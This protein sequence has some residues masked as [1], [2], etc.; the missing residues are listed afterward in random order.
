MTLNAKQLQDLQKARKRRELR[1]VPSVI[2]DHKPLTIGRGELARIT[3]NCPGMLLAIETTLVQ[4][5]ED[6]RLVDDLVVARALAC[7]IR[8]TTEDTEIVSFVISRLADLARDR[9]VDEQDWRSALRAIYT[10]VETHSNHR[11]GDRAYIRYAAKFLK[12]RR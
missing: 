1:P 3:N 5:A 2:I 6:E 11:D 4:C 12:T 7:S 8:G 9:R 10:S